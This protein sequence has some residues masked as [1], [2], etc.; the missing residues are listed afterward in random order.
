MTGLNSNI[1]QVV[2]RFRA[3]GAR[4]KG[5]DPSE[6]LIVGVNA[7]RGQMTERIFNKGQDFEGGSL[8]VYVG[9]KGR[10]SKLAE[11]RIFG[12]RKKEFLVGTND[13]F[14]PYEIKR[15]KKG[16][17]I[18]YKDLELFGSLRRGII[19]IKSSNTRVVCAIPNDKL[20]KIA[21]G[22]E[23]QIGR[24]LGTGV[25]VIFTPSQEEKKVLRENTTEALKQIYVRVFNS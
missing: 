22:Q 17:Q 1:D 4:V 11:Q 8:G 12:K 16:R 19:V 5:V 18:R 23:T 15:I 3:I 6:A 24:I 2:E 20:Y 14:S 25:T 13:Q 7:A 10:L 21:Q 9:K